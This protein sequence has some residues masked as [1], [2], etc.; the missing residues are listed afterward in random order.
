MLKNLQYQPKLK[1]AIILSN[2]GTPA[3]TDIEDVRAYLDQ[4]LMDKNVIDLA[5]PLRAFLVKGIILRTRPK[6]SAEAYKKIWTERGSPLLFH[7]KDLVKKLKL[8]E[9]L[10]VFL[11]M[12]YGK[13]SYPEII[14]QIQEGDFQQILHIPLYPQ[15]SSATTKTN[16]LHLIKCLK[17]AK[18]E[19]PCFTRSNFY[20]DTG[21]I[22]AFQQI[23]QPILKNFSAEKYIFSFHGLPEKML[24]KNDPT[25]SHCLMAKD[26]CDN[27]KKTTPNCYRAQCY[28]TSK[29]LIKALGLPT[30]LC[31]TTFQSRLGQAKWLQPYTDEYVIAQAQKGVKRILLFAPSFV[32]DC[33]ET[34]DELAIELKKEFLANGGEELV[35][36]P[37]LN[38]SEAWVHSLSQYCRQPIQLKQLQ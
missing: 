35:L 6:N 9:H 7:S 22:N 8:P 19:L 30:S 5:W 20:D 28:Q 17:K 37:S 31:M 26:C 18:L 16:E 33:L 29:A 4:F 12:R 25:A 38:S 36:A 3:S 11:A 2:L 21:F 34:L 27:F 15:Y 10:Q 24:K 13:P 1:T 32:A 23:A 14:T